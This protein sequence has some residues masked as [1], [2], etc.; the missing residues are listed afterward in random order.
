MLTIP[1]ITHVVGS[2]STR[3][4]AKKVDGITVEINWGVISFVGIENGPIF[5]SEAVEPELEDAVGKE[6]LEEL[7]PEEGPSGPPGP[8]NEGISELRP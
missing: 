7:P 1:R 6:V 4:G 2:I 3:G 5:V 8:S